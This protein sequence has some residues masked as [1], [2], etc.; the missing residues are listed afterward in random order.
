M[1]CKHRNIVQ[2]IKT[3]SQVFTLVVMIRDGVNKKPNY[4]QCPQKKGEGGNTC[5]QQNVF[6]DVVI[7]QYV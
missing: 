2:I 5:P 1:K 7:S 6:V 3:L 4:L